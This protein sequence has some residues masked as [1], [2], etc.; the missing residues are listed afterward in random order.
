MQK[1]QEVARTRQQY[2][3][4][5]LYCVGEPAKGATRRRRGGVSSLMAN[6]VTVCGGPVKTPAW[7][8]SKGSQEARG[9]TEDGLTAG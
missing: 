6:G 1:Q 5:G 7:R 8:N 4:Q 3:G 9:A 2:A